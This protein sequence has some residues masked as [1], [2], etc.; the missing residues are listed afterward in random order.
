MRKE[1]ITMS[2]D[3]IDHCRKLIGNRLRVKLRTWNLANYQGVRLGNPAMKSERLSQ[4]HPR[5]ADAKLL[6]F[7]SGMAGSGGKPQVCF[8]VGQ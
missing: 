7:A 1:G 3:E 4:P 5:G 2:L 8:K 6:I